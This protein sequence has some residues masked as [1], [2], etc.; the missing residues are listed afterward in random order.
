MSELTSFAQV[1]SR[2]IF[3][4]SRKQAS[5][6]ILV[7]SLIGCSLCHVTL[8][9]EWSWRVDSGKSMTKFEELSI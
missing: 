1:H 6:E 9:A 8:S 2:Q 3:V 4:S 7:V 5:T